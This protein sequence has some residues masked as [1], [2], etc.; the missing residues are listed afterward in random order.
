MDVT[1][2]GIVGMDGDDRIVRFLEKPRPDEVFSHWVNAGIFLL[3]PET[4][5]YIPPQGFSDFGREVFPVILDA[6]RPM[7]G[8][9]MSPDERLWW[10]DTL[11][12]LQHTQEEVRRSSA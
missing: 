2:S 3:E 11:Q 5:D 12:D 8:Y 6:G 1:Q 9:R 4:L 10:I 7:Y